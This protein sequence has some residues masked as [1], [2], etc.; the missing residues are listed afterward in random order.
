M[1]QLLRGPKR[2]EDR[3]IDRANSAS[4][5]VRID[6]LGGDPVWREQFD[7]HE[8]TVLVEI[9]HHILQLDAAPRPAMNTCDSQVRRDRPAI[10]KG[11]FE[12]DRGLRSA[13][14]R[15]AAKSLEDLD[16]IGGSAGR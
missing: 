10:S 7:A 12:R 9:D 6:L 4:G 11:G 1:R 3:A 5:Q 2:L 14:C 16:R 13:R 8:R 15:V